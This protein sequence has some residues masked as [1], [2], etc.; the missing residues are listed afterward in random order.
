MPGPTHGLRVLDFTQSYPGAL[1][2]MVL[3][4]GGAEVIKVEPPGGDPTR[5][6]YAAPMWHRGKKS[7]VLDLKTEAGLARARELAASSDVA[8]VSFRPGVAERLGIGYRDLSKINPGLVYAGITGFGPTGPFSRLRGYEGIVHAVAG[9]TA[10][11]ASLVGKNAPTFACLMVASYGAA[12][13]TVQGVLA[14]LIARAKCGRGQRVETSLVQALTNFDLA[15]YLGWQLHERGEDPPNAS[16]AG[17]PI[18]PYM[19]GRTK[20]GHWLQFGNL[21]VQTQ[22]N[23]LHHLGLDHLL[24][25]ERFQTAPKYETPEI[26]LEMQLACLERLLTKNLDE[27]M[28]I[29]MQ[30]DV[31]AEP[32]RTTQEGLKHEQGIHFGNVVQVND[33]AVGATAQVGPVGKLTATPMGPQGPA[34]S[35]GQHAGASFAPLSNRAS[36]GK[37]TAAGEPPPHPLSGVTVLELASFIAAPYA[38][39]LLADL[40]ARVIKVEPMTGD[41]YRAI[42]FPR[43][44]KTIQ[45]KE[46]LALDLKAPRAQEVLHRLARKADVLLHNFRPGVP[47]RL[48]MDYES[49]RSINP[50]IVYVY[51]GAYGSTGPHSPRVGM[52]PIAGAITGGPRYQVGDHVLPP[53]ERELSLQEVSELSDVLRRS[54]EVNPDPAAALACCSAVLNALYARATTGQGQYVETTMLGGNLYA[55]ADDALSYAGKPPRPQADK[56]MNGLHALYRLYPCQ[57]GWVFL[58]CLGEEAWRRLSETPGFAGVAG[59]PRF[60]SS[61]SRA[62]HDEALAAALAGLFETRPA[63]EWQALLSDRDVACVEVYEGDNGRF[64]NTEAWVREAGFFVPVEHPSLGAY[65]RQAPPFVFSMTPAV[66][67]AN[68]YLGEHTLPI[69]RELGYDGPS[70]QSMEA[71]GVVL[72]QPEMAAAGS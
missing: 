53:T 9:R 65:F 61:A 71:D 41:L 36:P 42:S 37:G 39:A 50:E 14:A 49:I 48:A 63:P 51:A 40:G 29:F 35:L 12:M 19:T 15:N 1:A 13:N 59:D 6:H 2:T 38:T 45:G 18:P 44:C 60:G 56:G 58:A 11:F 67:G 64:M 72:A 33:P 66:A 23:F 31:A 24:R 52:H 43:M 21:T 28:D 22:W 27:W 34:P 68:V 57:K 3:A 17:G 55:N 70:I 26:Q 7:L 32:F 20:D 46:G 5:R 10:T 47:E 4:D 62:E 25:E 30:G 16:Y 8:V 54:N 69:L